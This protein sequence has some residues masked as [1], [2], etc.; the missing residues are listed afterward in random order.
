MGIVSGLKAI[1]RGAGY[2]VVTFI[3]GFGMTFIM[4]GSQV[5][6]IFGRTNINLFQAAIRTSRMAPESWKLVGWLF[7]SMHFMKIRVNGTGFGFR[8]STA[9]SLYQSEA[10]SL[11]YFLIPIIIILAIGFL[12][13][14]RTVDSTP[15]SLA[16]T[17]TG[18]AVGYSVIGGPV[19][20][21]SSWYINS[22]LAS[23]TALPDPNAFPLFLLYPIVF[24][25]IGGGVARLL[26]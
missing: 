12:A 13:I 23:A 8:R 26:E 20:V 7:Y 11:F 18:L 3:L 17:V 5:N 15:Q 25:T 2:G 16:L 6:Q 9:V 19:L 22:G 24:G 4:V 14:R 21:L 1:I 10:W